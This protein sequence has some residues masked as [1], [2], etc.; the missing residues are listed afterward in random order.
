MSNKIVEIE[1]KVTNITIPSE[2]ITQFFQRYHIQK[3]SFFGSVLRIEHEDYKYIGKI[4]KARHVNE[5]NMVKKRR[6]KKNQRIR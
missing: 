6:Q 3:L 2:T 5:V 4:R 1:T